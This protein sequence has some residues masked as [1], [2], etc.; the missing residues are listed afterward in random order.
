MCIFHFHLNNRNVQIKTNS[1]NC[2]HSKVNCIG[3][4]CIF[5]C[6]DHILRRILNGIGLIGFERIK[7]FIREGGI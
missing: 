7:G 3:I 5:K 2:L 1:N 6:E 4:G